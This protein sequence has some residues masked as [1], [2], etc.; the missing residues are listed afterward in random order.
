MVAISRHFKTIFVKTTKTAGTSI[1]CSLSKIFHKNDILSP[2]SPKI[3]GH[4][5]RNYLFEN[6]KN[7]YNH[8]S[9]KEIIHLLG[10]NQYKHYFVWCIERHPVE[11]CISHFAMLKNS[12]F[13]K[14]INNSSE[15]T[16]DEYIERKRFPN[17]L[18]KYSFINS[19]NQRMPLVN[20]IIKYENL[21]KELRQL[22]LKLFGIDN[23]TLDFNAKS[24]FRSYRNVPTFNEVPNIQ[25]KEIFNHYSECLDFLKKYFGLY[26]SI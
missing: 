5:P 16:W 21:D 19:T 6:K 14:R 12:E 4:Q 23:F 9:A 26:Y 10:I 7:F 25:K 15:L 13:H 1:E 11:K 3:I 20:K 2:I 17:D 24:G 8:M 22:Y 18:N